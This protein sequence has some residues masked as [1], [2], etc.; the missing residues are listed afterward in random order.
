MRGGRTSSH[1]RAPP[2]EMASASPRAA[3]EAWRHDETWR[4]EFANH[5]KPKR[6]RK[7]WKYQ[8][9]VAISL[10]VSTCCQAPIDSAADVEV[11]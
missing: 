5:E 11:R 1:N 10:G 6:C 4:H 7:A 8:F 2:R 3:D 9:T